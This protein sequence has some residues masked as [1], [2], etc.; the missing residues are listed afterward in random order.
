MGETTLLK[1]P[2]LALQKKYLSHNKSYFCNRPELYK[3]RF[4]PHISRSSA[5]STSSCLCVCVSSL[6][7]D[8]RHRPP[9]GDRH[10]SPGAE[11]L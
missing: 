4:R 7:E 5:C 10:R 9:A 6:P 1:R 8:Q 2:T 3:L 11:S